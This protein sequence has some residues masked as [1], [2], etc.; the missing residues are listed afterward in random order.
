MAYSCKT[1]VKAL[2]LKA[3][4]NYSVIYP[5]FFIF[6]T[7]WIFWVLFKINATKYIP[8]YLIFKFVN[9]GDK[10]VFIAEKSQKCGS[11]GHVEEELS[12]GLPN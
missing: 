5:S 4:S 12:N 6:S 9:M 8:K 7:N 2:I 1:K 10:N 3:I 11:K